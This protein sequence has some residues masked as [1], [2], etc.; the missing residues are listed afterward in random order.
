MHDIASLQ[1]LV[2][3]QL[4]LPLEKVSVIK[5]V[6]LMVEYAYAARASDIHIEPAADRLRVRYRVDGLL[7]DAF[8]E[9]KVNANLH[10]EVIS[11]IKVLSGLRTD[12]HLLPQDGRFKV[13]I[14]D[15]GDVD[16]RVSIIPTYYGENA[17]LRV[18]GAD[19]EFRPGRPGIFPEGPRKDKTGD[20]E[21]LWHDSRERADGF[22]Q[23]DD[24]LYYS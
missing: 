3:E 19:A 12:E 20:H 24:A 9:N 18:L 6:D 7:S 21:A 13:K 17:I 8:G 10:P 16:V 23:D 14:E 22:R 2:E 11:R 5:L 1:A 15:F 4:K